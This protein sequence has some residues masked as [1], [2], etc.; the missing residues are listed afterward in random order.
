MRA[1]FSRV[2]AN[3]DITLHFVVE[4][5]REFFEPDDPTEDSLVDIQQLRKLRTETFGPNLYI[6]CKSESTADGEPCMSCHLF[7]GT[8]PYPGPITWSICGASLRGDYQYFQYSLTHTFVP[9]V[10]IGWRETLSKVTHWDQSDILREENALRISVTVRAREGP[11]LYPDNSLSVSYVALTQPQPSDLHFVTYRA[12][13][14]SGQVSDRRALFANAEIISEACPRLAKC[15][16]LYI[17][18]CRHSV[19]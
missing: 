9:G 6:E 13:R 10:G 4:D 17:C 19:Y 8:T 18:A 15:K 1:A 16:L 2:S 7:A 5:V 12:R 11:R 3:Y 14:N